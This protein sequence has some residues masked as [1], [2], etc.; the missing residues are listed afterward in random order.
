MLGVRLEPQ[1]EARLA[2]VA[3]ARGKTKSDIV[4]DAVRRHVIA[5]D[6]AYRLECRRQSL[7]AAARPRTDDDDFWDRVAEESWHDLGLA[8]EAEQIS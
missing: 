7:A 4:R 3:H 1:L 6:D 2:S 5:L 8:A